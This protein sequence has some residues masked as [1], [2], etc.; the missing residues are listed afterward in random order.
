[1]RKKMF[2]KIKFSLTR[3]NQKFSNGGSTFESI[4]TYSGFTNYG[5]SRPVYYSEIVKVLSGFSDLNSREYIDIDNL[6][7]VQKVLSVAP[8]FTPRKSHKSNIKPFMTKS[9]IELVESGSKMNIN[10]QSLREL[11]LNMKL[12][13]KLSKKY[14]LL[15]SQ[16]KQKD[17]VPEEKKASK[18]TKIFE[19]TSMA[20][21]KRYEDRTGI[22]CRAE[23]K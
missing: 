22:L 12:S 23:R 4:M 9:E 18:L 14:A 5:Q 20:F 2:E 15:S 13:Q 11:K 17:R 19:R 6:P 21:R 8:T 1:M 7:E 16:E 3:R 10:L